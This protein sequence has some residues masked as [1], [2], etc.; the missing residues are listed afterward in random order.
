[1]ET[2]TESEIQ[3]GRPTLRLVG[4]HGP[5]PE[6]LKVMVKV[7]AEEWVYLWRLWDQ[8]V[9]IDSQVD[10]VNRY[11]R[12]AKRLIEKYGIHLEPNQMVEFT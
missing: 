9:R 5:E 3:G 8:A 7:S 4:I 10:S 1:M 6:K 12:Y 2:K 11:N